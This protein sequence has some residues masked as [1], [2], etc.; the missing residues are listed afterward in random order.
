MEKYED[1]TPT[2]TP[3]F[4]MKQTYLKNVKYLK[5]NNIFGGI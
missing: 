3:P 5:T 2:P 1:G 4:Q